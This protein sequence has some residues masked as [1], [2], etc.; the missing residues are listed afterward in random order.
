M[1]QGIDWLG[2]RVFHGG[3]EVPSSI[4]NIRSRATP[5][6]S[7]GLSIPPC[8]RGEEINAESIHQH[9]HPS[10]SPT[11]DFGNNGRW[12]GRTP[13]LRCRALSLQ[14]PLGASTKANIKSAEKD[15]MYLTS[16]HEAQSNR[17]EYRLYYRSFVA[18]FLCRRYSLIKTKP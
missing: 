10:S 7:V 15:N 13:S 16:K 17:S 2:K 14:T 11:P 5:E 12:R 1:H 18:C 9:L 3:A 8:V 4:E 6:I